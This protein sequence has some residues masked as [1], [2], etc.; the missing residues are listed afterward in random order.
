MPS[1]TGALAKVRVQIFLLMYSI[2]VYMS[3]SAGTASQPPTVAME[4]DPNICRF[5]SFISF[6]F[7]CCSQSSPSPFHPSSLSLLLSPGL[8]SRLGD[9]LDQSASASAA[10]FS[11]LP[12]CE[13]IFVCGFW[14]NSFK[15][16]AS[17]TGIA[18][19]HMYNIG[20]VMRLH[21]L[22]R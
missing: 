9:P 19:L 21:V 10:C 5:H 1:A 14:D 18:V 7:F 12:S 16:F 2:C 17:N 20:L 11:S 6:F 22:Y 15:C 13:V 3:T 4:P 8:R